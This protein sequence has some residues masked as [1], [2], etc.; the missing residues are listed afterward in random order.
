[1]VYFDV[2]PASITITLSEENGTF[3]IYNLNIKQIGA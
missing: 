1:V 3:S 2:G